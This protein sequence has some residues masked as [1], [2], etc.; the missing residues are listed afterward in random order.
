MVFEYYAS[1]F[2]EII[3]LY[4]FL[5]GSH[6]FILSVHEGFKYEKSGKKVLYYYY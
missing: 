1:S 5:C 2:Y 6:K 3:I 4:I